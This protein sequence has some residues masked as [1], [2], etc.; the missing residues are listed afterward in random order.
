MT[1]GLPHA[2]LSWIEG[3][4]YLTKVCARAPSG[5]SPR[6]RHGEQEIILKAVLN[7]DL[8]DD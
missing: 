2:E 5:G 7:P 4:C 6:D 8:L 1:N 3:L